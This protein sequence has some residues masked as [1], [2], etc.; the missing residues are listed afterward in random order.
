M[1][2]IHLLTL[3]EENILVTHLIYNLL[4]FMQIGADLTK[5]SQKLKL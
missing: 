4:V 2:T 3:M 1:L 5:L